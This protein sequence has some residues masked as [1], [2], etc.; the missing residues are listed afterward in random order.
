MF[1]P[2][3]LIN[4]KYDIIYTQKKNTNVT[5]EPINEQPITMANE[6]K[7]ISLFFKVF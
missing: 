7:M 3:P 1:S 6:P 2:H 4:N 5:H